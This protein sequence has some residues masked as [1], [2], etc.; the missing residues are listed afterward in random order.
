MVTQLMWG[1]YTLGMVV[2]S[3]VI[4]PFFAPKPEEVIYYDYPVYPMDP[5]PPDYYCPVPIC[6]DGSYPNPTCP[7]M[8][9][10]DFMCPDGSYPNP[11]DCSCPLI[12]P[13]DLVCPDGYYSDPYNNCSC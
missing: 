6:P 12:C 3:I 8:C 2:Y 11:Y 4:W 5:L 9:V 1:T 13:A 7:D 10:A